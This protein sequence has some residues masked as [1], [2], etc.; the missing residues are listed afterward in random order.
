MEKMNQTTVYRKT[1]AGEDAVKQRTRLIQRNTRMV[2]IL[3]DGMSSVEELA[4]KIGNPLLAESALND[5][6]QAGLIEPSLDSR[7]VSSKATKKSLP[8][9]EGAG[10]KDGGDALPKVDR[11]AD[12]EHVDQVPVSQGIFADK[13]GSTEPI[14]QTTQTLQ[15]VAATEASNSGMQL[16]G[17][18]SVVALGTNSLASPDPVPEASLVKSAPI[19]Q[20]VEQQGGATTTADLSV[21]SLFPADIGSSHL[22]FDRVDA[23]GK[24]EGDSTAGADNNKPEA[25]KTWSQPGE[26]VAGPDLTDLRLLREKRARIWGLF[27]GGVLVVLSLAAATV[28]LFPSERFRPELEASIFQAIGREA[29]VSTVRVAF[30]PS[31]AI[32]LGDVLL[33]EGRGA[34]RIS[35]IRLHPVVSSLFAS[36]KVFNKAAI[37]GVEISQEQ[38]S[39]MADAGS[40]LSAGTEYLHIKQVSFERVGLGF[41]GGGLDDLFGEILTDERLAAIHLQSS[42]RL[43]RVRLPLD[44]KAKEG[45][46]FAFEA[47]GWRPVSGNAWIID[48]MKLNGL[49]YSNRIDVQD[50]VLSTM[51]GVLNGNAV[52][53]NEIKRTVLRGVLSFER[54]NAVR[55]AEV[56]GQASMLQGDLA[57]DVRFTLPL[58]DGRGLLTATEAEG[59][60]NSH[61]GSLQN[62]DFAEAIRRGLGKPVQGGTTSFE[63]LSARFTVKSGGVLFSPIQFSSGLLQSRGVID[64][65]E[66]GNLSGRFDVQMRGSANRSKALIS[67]A[68]SMK[69]PVTQQEK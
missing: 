13:T 9:Q 28:I 22:R 68:G 29:K 6:Q 61:R 65:K 66:N 60:L 5:L 50:F 47:F 42:D 18:A 55:I 44:Q 7:G 46:Q 16:S 38:L 64:V 4:R 67:I 11:A 41:P 25:A 51:D 24:G 30:T 56:L 49:V 20:Q 1:R 26:E 14:L 37:V 12:K 58:T 45:Q 10:A 19:K 17:S 33:G 23:K 36:R 63:Q 15:G 62:V 69:S 35:E 34:L 59:K 27:L 2:L 43:F 48:S 3:V 54:L 52:I 57:G 31:P 32:V 40:R 8:L 21:F 53:E 39:G